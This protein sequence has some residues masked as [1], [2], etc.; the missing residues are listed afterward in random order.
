MSCSKAIDTSASAVRKPRLGGFTLSSRHREKDWVIGFTAKNNDI[1]N[2][3][4]LIVSFE[5]YFGMCW[6]FLRYFR[7]NAFSSS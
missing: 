2:D 7:S 6:L 5:S 4:S 3:W 1:P